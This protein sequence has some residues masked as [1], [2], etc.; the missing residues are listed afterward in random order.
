MVKVV[1]FDPVDAA[2][3]AKGREA[4]GRIRAD[5][6]WE[7]WVLVG[8][9]LDLGRHGCRRAAQMSPPNGSGYNRIFS[10]WLQENGLSDINKEAR[11][12]LFACCQNLAAIEAWRATLPLVERLRL[13][14]PI[15]VWAQFERV[16]HAMENATAGE[17]T[18]L[19]TEIAPQQEEFEAGRNNSKHRDWT[20]Y[21]T[22]AVRRLV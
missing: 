22:A 11:S 20:W 10:Q 19:K 1:S 2:E 12:R 9:A 17:P 18:A 21:I 15:E 3:I 5:S 7:D 14:Q 16:A 13:N 6:A 4:W 8:K